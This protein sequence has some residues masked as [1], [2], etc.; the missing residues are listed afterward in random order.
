MPDTQEFIIAEFNDQSEIDGLWYTPGATNPEYTNDAH[1][2]VG[3]YLESTDD[4]A[5]IWYFKAPI[6]GFLDRLS[7]AFNG[8]ELSYWFKFTSTQ[9]LNLTGTIEIC[10]PIIGFLGNQDCILI[11][12]ESDLLNTGNDILLTGRN[13]V[14]L[15]YGLE[16]EEIP[17]AFKGYDADIGSSYGVFSYWTKITVPLSF[18]GSNWKYYNPPI[19]DPV[20]AEV[21]Q[22]VLSDVIG[23]QIRGEYLKGND[24]GSLDEVMF[25]P[26]PELDSVSVPTP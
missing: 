18:T 23:L 12:S 19:A 16:P 14:T 11:G 25:N 20:T 24:T 13:G 7:E 21:F 6:E 17:T 26:P 3:G 10:F 4:L 22:E 8:G 1:S 2:L 5:D 15:S 9:D